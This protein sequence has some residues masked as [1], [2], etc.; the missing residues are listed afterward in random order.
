[1]SRLRV[2][3][4]TISLD[5]YGAGADQS[6]VNPL[7]RGGES[8]HGWFVPTRTFQRM[9]SGQDEGSTAT[10]AIDGLGEAHVTVL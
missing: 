7:G 6:L 2:H 8:L 1:M 3:S 10:F 5:G 9:H 4:F